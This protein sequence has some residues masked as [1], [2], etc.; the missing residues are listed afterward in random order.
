M[1]LFKPSIENRDRSI[2]I[3]KKKNAFRALVALIKG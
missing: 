1:D 2:Y 3:K